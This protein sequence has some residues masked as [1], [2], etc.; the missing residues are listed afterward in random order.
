MSPGAFSYLK[1]GTCPNGKAPI[2]GCFKII[3]LKVYLENPHANNPSC[4]DAGYQPHQ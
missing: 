1:T 2:S 3:G 4:D